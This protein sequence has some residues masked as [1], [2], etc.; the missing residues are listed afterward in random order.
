MIIIV[1]ILSYSAI[2]ITIPS[3]LMRVNTMLSIKETVSKKQILA[4]KPQFIL[5]VDYASGSLGGMLGEDRDL[6]LYLADMTSQHTT[7]SNHI[8]N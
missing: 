1:D 7:L 2:L 5:A 6:N 4:V 8:N 3:K